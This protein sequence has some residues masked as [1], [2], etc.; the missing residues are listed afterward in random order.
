MSV[1][2]PFLLV[3]AVCALVGWGLVRL[4][5]RVQRRR[6][7]SEAL[8]ATMTIFDDIWHPAAVEPQ[9]EIQQAYE[10][11]APTP[12]PEDDEDQPSR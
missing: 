7:G 11:R 6:V 9:I 12:S 4:T 3:A 1:V 8:S 10:R 5:R 2:W